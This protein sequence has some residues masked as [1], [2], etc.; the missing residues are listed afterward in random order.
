M[1]SP[2]RRICSFVV[3]YPIKNIYFAPFRKVK[4]VFYQER[5]ALEIK[6]THIMVS[7]YAEHD[8]ITFYY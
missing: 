3:M 7:I 6:S 2:Y 8:V 5:S 4:G 1:Y